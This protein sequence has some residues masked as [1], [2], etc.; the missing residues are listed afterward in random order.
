MNINPPNNF[1]ASWASAW[2][3]D[4]YGYWQ[5]F[6]I[7]DPKQGKE[8]QQIM[9]WIPDGVF[10][11]GSPEDEAE[12]IASEE[13]QHEVIIKQGFWLADTACTQALWQAVMGENP[14]DFDDNEQNPVENISWHDS[15]AFI[16]KANQFLGEEFL[17][18]PSEAEWE[19]SC[20]AGTTTPF[21]TGETITTEQANFNGNYPYKTKKAPVEKGQYREKTMP[22]VSFSPNPWGLYQMHGNVWEWCY[23]V[24]QEDYATVHE[25]SDASSNRVLRGGSWFDNA[26]NLRSAFRDASAPD[27]RYDA[28]GLRLAGGFDPQ[29]GR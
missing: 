19:Y 9:R 25:P 21:S 24:F 26:R 3:E 8:V 22:V 23:D 4:A 13:K 14:S 28:F 10:K 11:M 27:I 17:R 12:R 6:E 29:A 16:K 20:R 15:Q 1:P 2:G 5:S 18:L 7:I